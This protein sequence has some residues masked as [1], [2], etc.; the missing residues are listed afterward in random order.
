MTDPVRIVFGVWLALAV[1]A[2]AVAALDAYD[3][4][5]FRL[6]D[7]ERQKEIPRGE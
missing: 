3:E 7:L 1:I 6:D 5:M 2:I 4:I